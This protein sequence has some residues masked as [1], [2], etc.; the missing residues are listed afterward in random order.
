[1]SVIREEDI[2]EKKRIT[3][4]IRIKEV[5]K[6]KHI[7]QKQLSLDIGI[8]EKSI[9]QWF[10]KNKDIRENNLKLLAN[11][12]DVDLDYLKCT[13]V[14]PKK[15]MYKTIKDSQ[16]YYDYKN[17][18]IIICEKLLGSLDIKIEY[19][20]RFENNIY[21]EK[22]SYSEKDDD[23]YMDYD[24]GMEYTI[25]YQIENG[26]LISYRKFLLDRYCDNV[27]LKKDSQNNRPIK[28]SF[29]DYRDNIVNKI[30]SFSHSLEFDIFYSNDTEIVF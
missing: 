14:F 21:I 1:M 3:P 28:M 25:D 19:I 12:L 18:D 2:I 16:I 6:E 13:Q 15:D 5:L 7:T 9:S 24:C 8:T 4:Q 30:I 29:N 10:K 26:Y 23:Y 22:I 11:Y 17:E 20:E 27:I